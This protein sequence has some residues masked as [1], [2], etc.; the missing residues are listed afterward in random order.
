MASLPDRLVRFGVAMEASLLADLDRVVEGRGSTRSEAIRD[1]ARELVSRSRAR[2]H[3]DA[4]ASLTLVYDHHV[5]DLSALLTDM[6]HE[7]GERV[8]STLHVHLTHDLCL[9]VIVLR[10]PAD[11]LQAAAERLLGARGVKQGGLEL[12]ALGGEDARAD[13][14]RRSQAPAPESARAHAHA[15]AGRPRRP[16]RKRP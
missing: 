1:L 2:L 11:E 4:V 16:A 5:R 15:P 14:P 8:R 10:G 12:V 6:Q 9:E 13:G 3:V 7:L